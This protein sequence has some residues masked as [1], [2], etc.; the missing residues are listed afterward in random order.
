MNTRLLLSSVVATFL[1]VSCSSEFDHSYVIS[2][3]E[4]V[5]QTVEPVNFDGQFEANQLNDCLLNKISATLT[6]RSS[7]ENIKMYPDYYGGSFIEKNGTL[8]LLIR[9]DLMSSAIRDIE[10]LNLD[11]QI[12]F[13][14]C[15]Y[16]YNELS[17]IMEQLDA[18]FITKST[19]PIRK[20]VS[21]YCI[22]DENNR[23]LIYLRQCND[24]GIR[25]FRDMF[26]HPALEFKQLDRI[27]N[28]SSFNVYP[29]AKAYVH[30]T[31]D[32]YGSFAF[33]AR[34][35]SGQ[36]RVGVVTA[37]H[38]TDVGDFCY[39]NDEASN[40][41]TFGECVAAS[42]AV[43]KADAAF[44]V[45]VA[46]N[47][48]TLSNFINDNPSSVLSTVVSNPGVG[49]YV[50]KWGASTGNSG[51]YIQSTTVKVLDDNDNVRF[52]DMT[53]ANYTSS[54]GDSGGIIYTYLSSKKVRYTVGIHQGSV[55]GKNIAVFTKASNAL[56]ILGL[57]RY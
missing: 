30:T 8:R 22:D 49:T 33:R 54:G 57:E 6:T 47:T 23:V 19:L 38:V 44:I 29:G 3:E 15:S 21:A 32:L 41:K 52:T 50:N 11:G 56:S 34:E 53:S 28:E 4:N 13:V 27:E 39:I 12:R 24:A 2:S 51:G 35:K 48:I 36:R 43:S 7:R 46:G 37:G 9:E 18:L 10:T 20:N 16:S 31:N 45:P 14:P 26:N 1:I 55:P 17:S 5:S 40:R 25:L 42:K